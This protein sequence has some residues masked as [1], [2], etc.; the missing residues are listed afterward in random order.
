[1]A[2]PRNNESI[3]IVSVEALVL[4]YSKHE[5][6][7]ASTTTMVDVCARAAGTVP[8]AIDD[9]CVSGTGGRG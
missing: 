6:N 7:G 4:D 2:V 1:M 8:G 9:Y 3:Q 5:S